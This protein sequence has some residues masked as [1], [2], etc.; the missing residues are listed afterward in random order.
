[1]STVAEMAQAIADA[2]ESGEHTSRTYRPRVKEVRDDLAW[3]QLGDIGYVEVR[4]DGANTRTVKAGR[5]DVR[6]AVRAAGVD[7]I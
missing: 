2:L 7:E 5:G 6:K 1:M 3:V 4:E